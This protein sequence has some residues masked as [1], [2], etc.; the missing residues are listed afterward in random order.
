MLR[1]WYCMDGRQ[2][3]DWPP[4]KLTIRQ[5]DLWDEFVEAAEVVV[6]GQ[7]ERLC[8]DMLIGMLDYQFK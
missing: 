6:A 3:E 1:I 7:M 5:G 2:D 4:Y 8:L